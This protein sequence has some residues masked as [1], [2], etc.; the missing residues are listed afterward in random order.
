MVENTHACGLKSAALR[1]LTRARL[2]S[3]ESLCEM[4]TVLAKSIEFRSFTTYCLMGLKM[5]RPLTRGV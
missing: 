2:P 5:F 4:F 3:D 1:A